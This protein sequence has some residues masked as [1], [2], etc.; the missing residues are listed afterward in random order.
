MLTSCQAEPPPPTELSFETHPSV[1]RGNWSGI[2]PNVPES[3][4]STLELTNITAECADEPKD[5]VP[6]D[7]CYRYTFAG[8][9][10]LDGS[11]PV[12][13]TGEGR[14]GSNHIYTLTS[15]IPIIEIGI[16]GS[17][18]LENETWNLSA[19][20]EPFDAQPAD[21]K[22]TYVGFILRDGSDTGG[23]FVLEPTP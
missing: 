23:S 15:P 16:E 11:T 22:P 18:S 12:P 4:N 17:F 8:S 7:Q 20:Y 14:S 6:E 10:S 1:L 9:I 3:K 13:L 2:I 21:A 19:N 5:N